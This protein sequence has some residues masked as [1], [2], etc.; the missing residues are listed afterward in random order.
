MVPVPELAPTSPLLVF[1]GPYS[2]L[3]ALLALK[4]EAERLAIPASHVICTGDVVAYCA[5]PEETVSAVRDWGI[6]VIAGNCEESLA[7]GAGD[8]GC[9][10][11]EGTACERLSKGWYPFA[12]ARIS[13][14][15]RGWMAGLP[16]TLHLDYAGTRLR[17]VHGGVQETA[18]WVFASMTDRIAEELELADSDIVLAG[19]C[20]LPTIARVGARVWFNPGVIGMPANDGTTDGWYGLVRPTPTGLKLTTHR[21][22]YDHVATA[23]AM[24]RHGHANEYA[25]TLVTGRWPSLDVLPPAERAAA[26]IRLK[27]QAISRATTVAAGPQRI[28]A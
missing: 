13:S 24:R 16:A 4:A 2:N 19:H 27:P 1:G 26:G 8:C 10:F 7:S 25:R 5:E 17:V 3:R 9:N 12:N 15:T 20:G 28:L 11:A 21:L 6:A 14:D 18:R 23:A 22:R